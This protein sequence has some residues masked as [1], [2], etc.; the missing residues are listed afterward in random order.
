MD[1]LRP[2]HIWQQQLQRPPSW[3]SRLPDRRRPAQAQSQLAWRYGIKHY[4]ALYHKEDSSHAAVPDQ[5]MTLSKKKNEKRERQMAQTRAQIISEHRPCAVNFQRGFIGTNSGTRHFP[6]QNRWELC[7]PM[8]NN[9]DRS[10]RLHT[11]TAQEPVQSPCSSS[12]N[13]RSRHPQGVI[14]RKTA[15]RIHSLLF[16]SSI[17]SFT[18]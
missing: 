6:M 14:W 18:Q 4:H 5:A 16:I 9:Q 15:W 11:V 8:A 7:L 2:L 12:G 3:C 17:S 13:R 1:S 10:F